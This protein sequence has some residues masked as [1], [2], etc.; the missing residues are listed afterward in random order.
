M[1]N[2]GKLFHTWSIWDWDIGIWPFFSNSGTWN[3][4]FLSNKKGL[5]EEFWMTTETGAY[6]DEPM[7]K[8]MAIFPI[9]NDA[10]NEQ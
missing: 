8:N 4:V 2:V 6:R 1:G 10:L 7:G 3:Y 5:L 9:L